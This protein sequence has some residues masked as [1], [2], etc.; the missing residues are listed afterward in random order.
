MRGGGSIEALEGK[1]AWWILTL[2]PMQSTLQLSSFK[3]GKRH[4]GILRASEISGDKRSEN[5]VKGDNS[6][7]EMLEQQ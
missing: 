1:G 3:K 5:S 7:F 6:P 2:L 4:E